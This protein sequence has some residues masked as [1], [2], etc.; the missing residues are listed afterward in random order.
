MIKKKFPVLNQ[1]VLPGKSFRSSM[2]D[3][4]LEKR[5]VELNKYLQTMCNPD[6]IANNSGILKLIMKFL[7][8]KKW[9]N[10][11]TTFKRR[12]DSFLTPMISSVQ[13]IQSSIKNAPDN[14]IGMVKGLSD[15][16][17][18]SS[19]INTPTTDST[20]PVQKKNLTSHKRTLTP[21]SAKDINVTIPSLDE[22]VSQLESFSRFNMMNYTI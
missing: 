12:V 18:M 5:R 13:N 11:Q 1:L 2:S 3:D 21:T 20:P 22:I 10:K 14:V 8:N 19:T 9:Q 17:L 16:I 15:N 7:E 6:V 4:F